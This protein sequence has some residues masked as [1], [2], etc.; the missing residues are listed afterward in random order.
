MNCI[1]WLLR[2]KGLLPIRHLFLRNVWLRNRRPQN[3][4][5]RK[6]SLPRGWSQG[7]WFRENT[8]IRVHYYE[9]LTGGHLFF[10]D[11]LF[12]ASSLEAKVRKKIFGLTSVA[13]GC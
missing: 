10:V 11:T 3:V 5:L 8:R 2:R 6:V 7:A 9:V 1:F 4:T 12:E 13:V